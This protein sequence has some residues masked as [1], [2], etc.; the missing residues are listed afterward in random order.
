MIISARK[1]LNTV[2]VDGEA[3]MKCGCRGI[4]KKAGKG[5]GKGKGLPQKSEM[6]QVVPGRLRHT[7]FLDVW[8]YESGTSSALSTG[9]L[10]PT[11]NPLYTF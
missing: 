8:H 1:V 7:D 9:R 2:E 3:F 11:R 10:Y 6:T 4:Y 5:K